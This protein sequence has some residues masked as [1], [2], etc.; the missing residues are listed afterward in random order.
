MQLI[1]PMSGIGKRFVEKG[2]NVPKPLISISGKPM[3]QHVVEMFPGVEEVLFIVNR[4]H[5]ENK[6]LE[7]ESKLNSL[8]PSCTIAVIDP[9]KH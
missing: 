2:Y 9:H 4:N 6:E 1:I 8:V 7:L 3:V 5:F